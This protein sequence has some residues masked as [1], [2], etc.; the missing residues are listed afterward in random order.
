MGYYRLYFFSSE[1]GRI[2]EVR[3]FEAPHDFAAI[4]QS[5]EWRSNEAM[6]LWC[7]TRKAARWMIPNFEK[8]RQLPNLATLMRRESRD[9][10][11]G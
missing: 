10:P 5:A 9:L 4:N 6:E 1:T 2:R 11:L 7:G 3:E 8:A